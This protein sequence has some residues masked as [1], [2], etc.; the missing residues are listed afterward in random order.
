[1]SP[2]PRPVAILVRSDTDPELKD[3]EAR[4]PRMSPN[5]L[6]PYVAP[7]LSEDERKALER[8]TFLNSRP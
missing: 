4:V 6:G 7:E 1:M 8:S 5:G 2:Q 3:P